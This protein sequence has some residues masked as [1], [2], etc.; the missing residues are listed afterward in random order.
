[1]KLKLVDMIKKI[2]I[3]AVSSLILWIIA[4]PVAHAACTGCLCPGNPCGLCSLPAMVDDTPIA[5]ESET[6]IKIKEIVPP[7]SAPPGT[8]EHF[9]NLDRSVIECVRNGG[10][11]VRNPRR[12]KEYPLKHYCKP[13]E[14]ASEVK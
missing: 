2:L 13:P 4:L 14:G 1:M 12:S 10:D 3:A 9:A 11:V 8:N 7:I 6:C 5:N